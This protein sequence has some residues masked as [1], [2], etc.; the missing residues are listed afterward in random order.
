MSLSVGSRGTNV[1]ELQQRLASAG[2]NPG[3]ADGIF[4]PKTQ[5]A[6][7]AFQRSNRLDDDGKV[8]PLTSRALDTFEP[9]PST[10]REPA[11]NRGDV[12]NRSASFDRISGPRAS[13]MA[14]GRI[15][16]NGHQYTFN[17]GGQGRGN[18]PA[19]NYEVTAHRWSRNDPTMQVGGV[20][21]SFALSNKYDPR[22]GDTRTLLRIHPDGGRAG[23]HGCMGIVGDAATQRRFREDMRAELERNGGRFTL[24]VG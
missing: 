22:V 7:E 8:G 10:V 2:F 3:K 4:G 20:G 18:L 21:Y 23:T 12:A 19:G 16:I 1:R 5:R 24:R 17:S 9:S 11:T 14:S 6:V 15:T 13:Q